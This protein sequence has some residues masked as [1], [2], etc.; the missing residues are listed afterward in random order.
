MSAPP[1]LALPAVP[2]EWVQLVDEEA[3][4]LTVVEL[5]DALGASC[6]FPELPWQLALAVAL[7]G[8]DP[9]GQPYDDEHA[10][11]LAWQQALEQALGADGRLVATITSG[12][13]REF[14][15]Y[16]RSDDVVAD[17]A[18]APP[19]GLASFTAEVLLLPDPSWLGLRE[20][21]GLLG[22]DEQPLR[23][24]QGLGSER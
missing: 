23:A 6:P 21:A 22:E 15:A 14:V 11:L 19:P 7:E 20:I 2:P 13:V 8:P 5:D 10:A 24:P 3:G 1:A 9:S 17:W 16:L 12:G 4:A 18:D